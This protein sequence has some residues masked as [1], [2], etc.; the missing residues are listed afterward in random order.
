MCVC[1]PRDCSGCILA[2]HLVT[3]GGLP[4]PRCWLAIKLKNTDM[5]KTLN[6]H[7]QPT[8]SDTEQRWNC[9]A[10]VRVSLGQSQAISRLVPKAWFMSYLG[11][12][13]ITKL[14]DRVCPWADFWKS[15]DMTKWWAVARFV[16]I[17]TLRICEG[18]PQF[19]PG[20]SRMTQH[21]I[22]IQVTPFFSMFVFTRLQE[23]FLSV[24]EMP[25]RI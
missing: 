2:S 3:K 15:H 12:G 25:E 6:V 16:Q 5:L 19:A 24:P 23:G 8:S 20:T 4:S 18:L 22:F 17:S 14:A 10:W 13:G 9:L 1:P 21:V 7:T 11:A